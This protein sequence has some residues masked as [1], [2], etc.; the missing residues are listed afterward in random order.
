[1][2]EKDNRY[3]LQ[4]FL[5]ILIVIITCFLSVGYAALSDSSLYVYGSVSAEPFVGMFISNVEYAS[6]SGA[7]LTNSEIVSYS[8][9]M[10]HTNITLSPTDRT[11]SITY[12]VTIFNNSDSLKQF[13]GITYLDGL[14][15]NNDIVYTLDGL[16]VKDTIERGASKTFNLTFSYK[17]NVTITNNNLDSYLSFNFDYYFAEENEV[18]IVIAAGESYEF[19]GVSPE[20]PIDLAN[21]AN[22]NFSIRNGSELILTGVNVDITYSTTSGSLQSAKIYLLDESEKEVSNQTVQFAK[23]VT[24]K[25]MRIVFENLQI[26]TDMHFHISFDKGTVTNGKVK[27]TR[28]AIS[29]IFE[30]SAV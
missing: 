27:V 22:I 13:T 20:N 6:N 2:K 15:S 25:D 3:V 23:K 29:P 21:I 16:K 9:T 10:L 28:V 17:T 12:Q 7:D 1:M 26:E 18:D 8:E 19:A 11:S 24:N 14:Y 5:G 30:E 4:S